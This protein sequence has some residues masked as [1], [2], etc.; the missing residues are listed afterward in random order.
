MKGRKPRGTSEATSFA[1]SFIDTMLDK[2]P[3]E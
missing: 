3:F 2:I 1:Y